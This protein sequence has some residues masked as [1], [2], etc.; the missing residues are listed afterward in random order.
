MA[1]IQL[2]G[3]VEPKCEDGKIWKFPY[4]FPVIIR[5]L[6]KTSHTFDL[7]DTHLHKKTRRELLDHLAACEAKVYGISAYSEGYKFAK[8]TAQA[9]RARHPDAVII[10]GGLLAKSDETLLKCT[11]ID[12]AVTAAD[13][14]FVLPELLD[15]LD[16]GPDADLSG[17]TGISYRRDGQVIRTPVRPTMS[18]EEYQNSERPAY[19]YFD[20]ELTELARNVASLDGIPV[21][22]FPLLVTRG[23]PFECTFC[24]HM[25]G[26]KFLR[27]KWDD[28]FD[29]VE[30]LVKRYGLEGVYSYD[31]NLFLNEREVEEYCRTYRERGCT[32]KI[33]AEVRPTF[34]NLEMFCKLKEHGVE[35]IIF[36]WESGSR[37]ML[38]VMRKKTDIDTVLRVARDA[39]A[40]GIVIYGNFLFGMPGESKETIRDTRRFMFELDKV[41][42]RQEA[43]FRARGI[44]YTAASGYSYSVLMA[45]PTSEVFDRIVEKGLIPDMDLYLSRLDR[46]AYSHYFL[47]NHSK[48]HGSD[49]NLTDFS[50]KDALRAFIRYSMALTKVRAWWLSPGLSGRKLGELGRQLRDT[51]VNGLGYVL[52]A[53]RDRVLGVPGAIPR[54]QRHALAAMLAK[55]SEMKGSLLH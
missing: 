17:I 8:E 15:A 20:K 36:G 39:A 38:N 54:D 32:F 35:V 41:I 13:G 19:E 29:E 6:Q 55:Q 11:E 31:T 30:F 48:H 26:R 1:H 53:A 51:A 23:C 46:E 18:K 43:D 50:S 12:I 24:G 40:A 52:L 33:V 45:L 44:H 4:A 47:K 16:R 34:G 22:G 49:I 2:I 25:Y 9:I 5:E 27:R 42:T 7:V 21:K 10:A 3:I 28:F 14:Q 37:K